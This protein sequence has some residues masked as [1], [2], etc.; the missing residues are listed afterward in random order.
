MRASILIFLL[1]VLIHVV[2]SRPVAPLQSLKPG[3]TLRIPRPFKNFN[4]LNRRRG[5]RG[6][7]LQRKCR[8][9]PP[10]TRTFNGYCNNLRHREQGMAETPFLLLAPPAPIDNTM[11][12]PR[13]V[14]NAVHNQV[15]DTRS[16]R[17][18]S[19][20]VTFFGQ[21][22][23]HT[24]AETTS[25]NVAWNIPVPAGDSYFSGIIPFFRSKKERTPKG[26]APINLL[27]SYID[28]SSIY[29][30]SEEDAKVLRSF[31]K[32]KMKMVNNHL[33]TKDGFYISGDVRVNENPALT[34]MHTLFTREHNRLCDEIFGAFPLWT[35]EMI[36]HM[37]RKIVGA[38]MQAI[39]Y[40][41]FLPAVIGKVLRYRGYKRR[42]D[43]TLSNE[44][45]TVAYRVGHTL[46]NSVLTLISKSGSKKEI[47]LRDAF[48]NP[49]VFANNDMDDI[50]R[51]IISTRAAE[52]DTQITGEVRNFLLGNP[53]ASVS[54]DLASLN[55]QRGRDHG[56]PKY[57]DLRAV[58]RLRRVKRFSQITKDVAVAAALERVYKTVDRI[59]PWTGGLAERH[60]RSSSLG[61]LFTRAWATEFQRLRH[62][63]RFYFENPG[64]FKKNHILRI[65]TLYK[66]VGSRRL[67]GKTM[68]H[69]IVSNTGIS[70]L[71]LRANVFKV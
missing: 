61:S 66:L 57:N 26:P 35:D 10:N 45:A 6:R 34:A 8:S 5:R 59:D 3:V 64:I 16:K 32:G 50:I 55:I 31:T 11:P 37:A 12:N 18:L 29:G 62:G 41:E 54:L 47:K 38:Q 28:A 43:A 52:V 68:K 60:H 46:I 24:F 22:L 27:S 30:I 33:T 49:S 19:E 71:T 53:A 67:I 42:V 13:E 15:A 25:D 56:I 70:A 9:D 44:F 51:G 39:T 4:E 7:G 58:Y 69:V 63:D 20:M 2:T 40:Y 17:R 48:F 14:S 23:D 36:F 21:L 65:P 1:L